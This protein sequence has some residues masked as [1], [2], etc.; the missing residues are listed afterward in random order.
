MLYNYIN[1]YYAD[2]S[3]NNVVYVSRSNINWMKL[4]QETIS[5]WL[6]KNSEI[7]KSA[8]SKAASAGGAAATS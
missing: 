5:K 2:K 1:I 8:T 3:I 7:I 4:N 6:N